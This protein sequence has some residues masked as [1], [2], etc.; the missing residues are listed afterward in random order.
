MQTDEMI[1][2]EGK[3]KNA[4]ETKNHMSANLNGFSVFIEK[5]QEQSEHFTVP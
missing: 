5:F 4:L 2:S 1:D 3:Q